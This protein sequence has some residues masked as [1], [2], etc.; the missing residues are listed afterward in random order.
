[1]SRM[2]ESSSTRTPYR[3]ECAGDVGSQGQ[4]GV[5]AV[6]FA[7]LEVVLGDGHGVVIW[8]RQTMSL[9]RASART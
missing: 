1:M 8:A 4:R 2:R 9:P 5:G 6:G 7:L 3:D